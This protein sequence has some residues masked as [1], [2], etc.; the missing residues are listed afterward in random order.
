[1]DDDFECFAEFLDGTFTYCGCPDC[2]QREY[3][4]A[5]PCDGRCDCCVSESY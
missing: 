1:M 4:D 5:M 3:D 2:E